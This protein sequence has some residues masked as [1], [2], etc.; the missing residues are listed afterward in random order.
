MQQSPKLIII[1][2]PNGSGKT[3]ITNQILQHE[4]KEG[5]VY[6]NPDEIAQKKYGDWN[7]RVN[8]LK[9]AKFA[10]KQRNALIKKKESI[11]FE[12]VFSSQEKIDFLLRAKETGYF[13]RLFFIGTNHPSIN[14][15]RVTKRVLE[16]GHDVPI[17]KIIDRYAKSISN[18]CVVAPMIDRLYVYDNSVDY[19]DARLLFRASNGK[20]TKKYIDINHWAICISSVLK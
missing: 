11:I 20:M 13:I 17:P 6:I 2:G 10:T 7:N 1:A 15:A 14:A 16:G 9:A 18:C 3:T 12:T 4:W 5:C 8:V 19:E